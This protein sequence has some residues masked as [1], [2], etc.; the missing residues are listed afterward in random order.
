M[1]R[2]ISIVLGI[3]IG[4]SMVC[5]EGNASEVLVMSSVSV[6]ENQIRTTDQIV[7]KYR[8]FKGKMQYRRWNETKKCWVDPAWIDM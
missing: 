7:K 3:S 4:M 1:K 5:V 2:I 6:A 8:E